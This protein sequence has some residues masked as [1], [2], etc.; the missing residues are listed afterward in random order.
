[1]SQ[2]IVKIFKYFLIAAIFVCIAG[3]AVHPATIGDSKALANNLQTRADKL[4][5]TAKQIED[6]KYSVSSRTFK[7]IDTYDIDECIA[8]EKYEVCSYSRSGTDSNFV[9]NIFDRNAC[10][11]VVPERI[12]KFLIEMPVND[13]FLMAGFRERNES[14]GKAIPGL[15][16]SSDYLI[17]LGRSDWVRSFEGPDTKTT[18]YLAHLTSSKENYNKA[19][20]LAPKG[21]KFLATGLRAFRVKNG[22]LPE[23]V[24]ES[25]LPAIPKLTAEQKKHSEQHYGS[26]LLLIF[27]KLQYAPVMRW[28]ME[29][30]PDHPLPSAD[31]AIQGG[32]I[33]PH[34]GFVVWNGHSFEL[35]Q[36]V[37]STQWPRCFLGS[38]DHCPADRKLYDPFLIENQ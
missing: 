4:A 17:P 10:L 6:C 2:Q 23:E 36:R 21:S 28:T 34:F 38:S 12:T 37:R 35:K 33:E 11:E 13:I 7:H 26:D 31:P 22:G 32:D 15:G 29:F 14:L 30:D 5:P 16:K 27:N 9:H 8:R 20:E 18:V 25:I 24:T 19:Q 3:C 1:M